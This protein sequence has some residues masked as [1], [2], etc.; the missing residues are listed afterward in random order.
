MIQKNFLKFPMLAFVAEIF[1]ERVLQASP[2]SMASKTCSPPTCSKHCREHFAN[3]ANVS[4][5]HR[6]YNS[7]AVPSRMQ[8][9][10]IHNTQSIVWNSFLIWLMQGHNQQPWATNSN[11]DWY[12]PPQLWLQDWR[13]CGRC[14]GSALRRLAAMWANDLVLDI[15]MMNKSTN[16]KHILDSAHGLPT[17]CLIFESTCR[18]NQGSGIR[19][20][21]T[22]MQAEWQQTSYNDVHIQGNGWHPTPD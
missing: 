5:L 12:H 3:P 15:H 19:S 18:Q 8:A 11:T 7:V 4:Q 2:V 14:W 17:D 10:T 21:Y 6:S 9:E 22:Y 20:I 16:V 1:K 13:P